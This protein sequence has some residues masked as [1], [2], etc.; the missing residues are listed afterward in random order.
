M[1]M[2]PTCLGLL[3][4]VLLLAGG[5]AA[6][7]DP[8][9]G[10]WNG[11]SQFKAGGFDLS[12]EFA[13][14]FNEDKTFSTTGRIVQPEVGFTLAGTYAVEGERLT[15]TPNPTTLKTENKAGLPAFLFNEGKK[16]LEKELGKVYSGKV[17]W[18]SD[19]S[20][21]FTPEGAPSMSLTKQ[22]PSGA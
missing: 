1:G 12:L 4:I 20:M 14:T 6:K 9:I 11:T 22:A 19:T 21:V 10:T 13:H 18:K 2:R 8:L 16:A 17:E 5:C 3:G 15:I 7:K